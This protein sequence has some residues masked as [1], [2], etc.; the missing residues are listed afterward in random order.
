MGEKMQEMMK[1]KLP[2]VG[3]VQPLQEPNDKPNTEASVVWPPSLQ[4]YINRC[5]AGAKTEVEKNQVEVIMRG[6]ITKACCDGTAY[7]K[8]WDNEPL[9]IVGSSYLDTSPQKPGNFLSLS[10]RGAN[11]NYRGKRQ[12]GRGG[13]GFG[14]N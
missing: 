1:S 3:Q 7:T 9:V 2:Q 10:N 6:R 13:G 8:N 14:R 4:K 11:R 12:A 5:L